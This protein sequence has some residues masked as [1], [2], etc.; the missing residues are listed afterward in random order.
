MVFSLT[1]K[2]SAPIFNVETLFKTPDDK[3]CY[4][5]DGEIS[6]LSETPPPPMQLWKFSSNSEGGGTWS[7]IS[8][9]SE[10]FYTLTRLSLG[11]DLSVGDT[12]LY[13]G[14]YSWDNAFPHQ[15]GF[16]LSPALVTYN[17]TSQGWVSESSIGI[18]CCGEVVGARAVTIPAFG[19]DGRELM[20]VLGGFDPLQEAFIWNSGLSPNHSIP[21]S[22]I[23]IYDPYI[24]AWFA[25][26]ASGDVP[27]PSQLFCAVSVQGDNGTYEMQVQPFASR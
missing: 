26:R 16:T 6:G 25:Q 21:F 4:L 8:T 5:W 15:Q 3:S 20:F 23:T 22:N 17:Y 12:G 24:G 9:I 1:P 10:V 27:P 11:A 14:G 13:L 18:G 19:L 7:Q 2:G